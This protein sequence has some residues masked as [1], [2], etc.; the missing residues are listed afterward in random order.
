MQN[1]HCL[2]TKT[3]FHSSYLNF[4]NLHWSAIGSGLVFWQGLVGRW[5]GLLFSNLTWIW[6][7]LEYYAQTYTLTTRLVAGAR[8][9]IDMLISYH[10]KMKW[11]DIHIDMT[12]SGIDISKIVGNWIFRAKMLLI[13]AQ[14]C[15]RPFRVAN[16]QVAGLKISHQRTLSL[17]SIDPIR[18]K[19]QLKPK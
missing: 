2:C 16:H 10:I 1:G 8:T 5:V 17:W 7:P 12:L 6:L 11:Y 18:T 14:W 15:K 3:W 9:V 13:P 4:L 19:L